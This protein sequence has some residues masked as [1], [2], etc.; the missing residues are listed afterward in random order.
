MVAQLV[1]ALPVPPLVSMKANCLKLT[2]L[3][4]REGPEGLLWARDGQTD[5][6]SGY[7][8]IFLSVFSGDLCGSG[9]WNMEHLKT[10][11]E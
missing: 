2:S 8:L 4:V 3:C 5:L 10:G 9:D 6:G 7:A 1:S 11:K